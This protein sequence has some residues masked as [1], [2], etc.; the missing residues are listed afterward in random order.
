M[1]TCM[2]GADTPA[3]GSALSSSKNPAN[4][5]FLT[6]PVPP[7]ELPPPVGWLN[8]AAELGPFAAPGCFST[9]CGCVV[10]GPAGDFS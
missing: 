1:L 6:L 4:R 7:A 5:F 8:G 3:A 2:V 10:P 9:D